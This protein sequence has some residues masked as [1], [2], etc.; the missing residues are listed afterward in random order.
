[1]N[2]EEI[3]KLLGW[4]ERWT[5]EEKERAHAILKECIDARKVGKPKEISYKDWVWLG[6]IKWSENYTIPEG[7][8]NKRK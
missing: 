4:K 3:N 5:P 6:E 7:Y 8:F 2:K 1:M